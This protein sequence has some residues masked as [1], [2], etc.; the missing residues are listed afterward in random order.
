MAQSWFGSDP[1]SVP[2]VNAI[3]AYQSTCQNWTGRD[4]KSAVSSVITQVKAKYP[5]EGAPQH[6]A[7]TAE[8]LRER[9][10]R[11]SNGGHLTVTVQGPSED[12]MI[13]TGLEVEII[14][15]REVAADELLFVG[16]GCGAEIPERYFAIDLDGAGARPHHMQYDADTGEFSPDPNPGFPYTVSRGEAEVLDITTSCAGACEWKARLSWIFKGE[17]GSAEITDQGS[18]FLTLQAEEASRRLNTWYMNTE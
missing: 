8:G 6:D 18:P 16:A 2:Y 17:T 11:P 10:W 13:L 15:K 12:V 3:T 5:K 7:A 1:R 4:A 14:N 9:G